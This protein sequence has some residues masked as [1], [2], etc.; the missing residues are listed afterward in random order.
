MLIRPAQ[1]VL[2][3]LALLTRMPILH[4]SVCAGIRL[5]TPLHTEADLGLGHTHTRI[6]AARRGISISGTGN[7]AQGHGLVPICSC[8]A[9]GERGQSLQKGSSGAKS[10]QQVSP[11]LCAPQLSHVRNVNIGPAAARNSVARWLAHCPF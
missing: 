9:R 3:T 1:H 7:C 11:C 2:I 4:A 5:A 6:I 8:R 10:N